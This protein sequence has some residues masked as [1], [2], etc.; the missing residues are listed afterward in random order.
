MSHLRQ[1]DMMAFADGQLL[2]AKARI[3]TGKRV[4]PDLWLQING[5]VVILPPTV[6]DVVGA[7]MDFVRTLRPDM[8]T[9]I[10]EAWS[11]ITDKL[12]ENFEHEDLSRRND[13]I[14][15]LAQFAKARNGN[16]LFRIWTIDRVNRR[17]DE[18]PSDGET[19]FPSRLDVKW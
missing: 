2:A 10:G 18:I 15:V 12:P 16:R 17:I 4:E 19:E 8:F 13:R 5:Q 3:E 1:A 7:A 11:V 14:D 6:E 9:F